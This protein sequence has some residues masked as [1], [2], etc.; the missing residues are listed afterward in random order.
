V[1]LEKLRRSDELSARAIYESLILCTDQ[2]RS[3][4]ELECYTYHYL[5]KVE[6]LKWFLA[7]LDA[8]EVVV[9]PYDWS[10]QK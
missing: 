5:W 4:P 6:A 8:G 1:S 2:R 9:D 3:I 10:A 7:K